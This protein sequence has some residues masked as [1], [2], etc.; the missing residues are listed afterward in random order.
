MTEEFFD[1]VKRVMSLY[2]L[3]NGQAE[4]FY[5]FINDEEAK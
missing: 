3:P 2:Q 5:V 1:L 4:E